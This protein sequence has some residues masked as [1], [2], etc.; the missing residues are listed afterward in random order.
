MFRYLVGKA[1]QLATK[2]ARLGFHI[3]HIIQPGM[4]YKIPAISPPRRASRDTGSIPQVV[5]QTNYTDTVTLPIYA[6]WLFNRAAAPGFTFRWV[7]DEE[8]D[9]FVRTKFSGR[10]WA[11]YKR[12]Q[13]GAAKA[14]FWR[15]LTLFHHGGVYLDVDATLI[16]P[17][18]GIL[19]ERSE[20][21]L[22]HGSNFTNYFFATEAENPHLVGVIER[23]NQNIEEN[24]LRSV[25]DMTGPTVFQEELGDLDVE[26]EAYSRV[27]REG[28]FTSNFFQYLDQPDANWG[29][30]Q[31]TTPIVGP[32]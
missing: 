9:E 1:I 11:N 19:K 17:L 12:L 7:C 21:F 25:Y 16:W 30:K 6:N 14:D 15:V 8:A 26:E 20:I 13:I 31:K 18:S 3:I 24:T 10:T 32:P 2:A 4:R 28:L 23:I 27:C 22:R 29:I 5:W